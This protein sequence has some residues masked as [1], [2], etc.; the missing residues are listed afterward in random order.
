[1]AKIYD[2]LGLIAPLTLTAKQIYRELCETKAPWDAKINGALLQRWKKWEEQLPRE[3]QVP[4]SIAS[5]Q[6]EIQAV[7]LHSFGDASE[8]GEGA[9]VYAVVRQPSGNTQRLVV[10]KS[11]LAKQ[12]LT[13]PHLELI[14]AH[15]A[16]NLL[17]N[18]RNALDNLP[19]PKVFGW[20]DST[21]TLHWIKGNGQ[22]KQ[23]VANRVA[24]IQLYKEIEWRYVPTDENPA[25]LASRGALVH[26]VLWQQGPAW[27][28]DKSEWPINSVTR[29]SPASEV[30]AKV[31]RE[32][33]N[34]AQTKPEPDKFEE[35]LE[36]TSLRRTL[37]VCAW[38]K[39]F[40]H[41]CKNK[42]NK[43]GPLLTE[44]IEDVRGW[45]IKRVQRR[46]KETTGYP[47]I[48]EQLNLK[49]NAEGVMTCHGRIQGQ[50]PI[51]LPSSERFTEKLVHE[52]HCETLHGGVALT[53][54]AVRERYW[55]PKLRSLVKSVRSKCYGCKRFSATPA[56]NPIPGQLP[57]GRTTVGGAFEV[58]GLDFPGPLKYK[59]G[60]KSQGNAYLAIFTCS[61]SRAI[62]LELIASLE[63]DNF[64]ACLKRFIA[65]RGRPR[66]IYS[67]NGGTFIKAEKWLRQ[68]RDDER[69]H[70]L[71]EQH[72]IKWKF[73]L[74]RA[75]WWGGQFERLIGVVKASMYKAIGGA[76][77][78][79]S[80]LSEVLLH[81][82]TQVNR[83]PLS[84]VEDDVELPILTPATFLYQRTNH[85][86]EEETWRI[87]D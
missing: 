46:D 85:L 60:K 79:W 58:I 49:P 21:V 33:L 68:L 32:V 19:S 20:L 44:E 59:E 39:R 42:E 67:D 29:S 43:L 64:I 10:A 40:I 87:T 8:R 37:R 1:M 80:E 22:Y 28:Q 25:D 17:I 66:V 13:I 35:L 73:N 3:Q 31:I 57:D 11:R 2:P 27:V 78:T 7:E 61:L 9:A 53:M 24:K 48:S 71:L 6:E 38:I 52:V 55:V 74:S 69:L 14:A 62:H 5:Y 45:W 72:E 75:P 65:R 16:T 84:Y 50:T 41:N 18:V 4:R 51:Y 36:R 26:S 47:Q 15:M 82:E 63:T 54:A 23:F 70:G 56:R 30:E 12:G 76:T 83:R 81:V 86:P 77:L 34:L